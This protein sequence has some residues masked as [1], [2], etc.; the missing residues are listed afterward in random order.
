LVG[1]VCGTGLGAAVWLVVV[2]FDDGIWGLAAAALLIASR[3]RRSINSVRSTFAPAL[4]LALE[5][6]G[7]KP[8][9]GCASSSAGQSRAD[10]SREW[11]FTQTLRGKTACFRVSL[12]QTGT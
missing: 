1:A 12:L 3:K 5:D 9:A 7:A 6:D 2:A 11:I 4:V 10:T 8:G